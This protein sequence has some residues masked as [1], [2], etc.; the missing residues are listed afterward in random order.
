LK[1][2]DTHIVHRDDDEKFGLTTIFDLSKTEALLNKLIRI[3]SNGGIS[4]LKSD[5]GILAMFEPLT[6]SF[7]FLRVPSMAE[8]D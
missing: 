5:V 4:T 2:R 7:S 3:A 1:L 6:V 8:Q